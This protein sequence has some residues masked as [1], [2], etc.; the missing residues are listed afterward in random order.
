[1]RITMKVMIIARIFFKEKK[2]LSPTRA[3]PVA[4]L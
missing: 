2:M 4:E 3:C 1:M